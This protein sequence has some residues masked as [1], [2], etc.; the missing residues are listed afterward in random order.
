MGIIGDI[1]ENLHE[2][3]VVI[4]NAFVEELS[5]L[6]G[7]TSSN[8]EVQKVKSAFD[9]ALTVCQR[10]TA[11]GDEDYRL[12]FK[13][14]DSCMQPLQSFKHKELELKTSQSVG[15][16][17]DGNLLQRVQTLLQVLQGF[18]ERVLQSMASYVPLPDI[19]KCI[20]EEH[21]NAELG[22]FKGTLMGMLWRTP[23]SS[24]SSRLRSGSS[25]P[26]C[27]T[28]SR[29]STEPCLRPSPRA[30]CRSITTRKKTP[31]ASPAATGCVNYD[32]VVH[33]FISLP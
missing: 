31:E 28:S 20:V 7:S 27:P 26:I 23:K 29:G 1:R 5:S 24:T 15:L 2:L 14:L 6:Q 18:T 16:S 4:R 3:T 25:C 10:H 22:D 13:V 32:S 9:T 21:G 17:E 11:Q 8:V 33:F 19:L 30:R 12:W